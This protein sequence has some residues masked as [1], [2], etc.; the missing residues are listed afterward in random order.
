MAAIRQSARVIAF[1]LLFVSSALL[2][3]GAS[4]FGSLFPAHLAANSQVT[5][6][7]SGAAPI[8][9][10]EKL[11]DML[12]THLN[13]SA[14][15]FATS[16]KLTA[17]DGAADNEF[18]LAVAVD[19]D[20]AVVGARFADVNNK[21]NQGAAY[22]FVYGGNSWAWQA[23]LTSNDGLAGDEFGGAVAV[24]GDWLIVGARNA[25]AKDGAAYFFKQVNGTWTPYG[26]HTPSIHNTGNELFGSSVALADDFA[27]VGAE[28]A[29][30]MDGGRPGAAYVFRRGANNW[31]F[32]QRVVA[33]EPIT[34]ARFGHSV[35]IDGS[36]AL[37]GAP[38]A[39]VGDNAEQGAAYVFAGFQNGAIWLQQARLI[40][41][42]GAMSDSFGISVALDGNT[43]LIG[44]Y[45]AD[46]NGKKDQ[47]AA[48]VFVR[49]QSSWSLQ[50]KLLANGGAGR[51]RFGVATVLYGNTALVGA[52]HEDEGNKDDQGAAYLFVRCGPTWSQQARLLA[53]D[54]QIGDWFGASV[55]LTDSIA[56]VGAS[57]TG[58]L[59]EQR[60]P[61]A[62]YLFTLEQVP[63]DLSL[64]VSANPGELVRPGQELVY[65]L[66]YGNTCSSAASGVVIRETVPAHTRFD[67]GAS[68]PSVWSCPDGSG[69]GVICRAEIGVVAAE[70][71]GTL[72]FAVTVENAPPNDA[73][74]IVNH[75]L[76][77]D[78]GAHGADLVPRNN[79]ASVYTPLV[80]TPLVVNKTAMPT[81]A[82]P[83]DLITYTITISATNGEA[84]IAL[85]DTL[86][87]GVTFE[88]MLSGP[89]A[90]QD[91]QIRFAG[92]IPATG[93]LR[94]AYQAKIK[95]EVTPG[96]IL[97]NETLVASKGQLYAAAAGVTVAN[98]NPV[99]T[100]VLIYVVG[101]N[102][103]AEHTRRL[104]QKAEA[105]ASNDPNMVMLLLLD[106]PQT[107]DAYYYRLQ[108]NED[109]TEYCPVLGNFDCND[110]Y[111]IDKT[112]WQWGEATG[113]YSSLQEFV[114]RAI[115]V[116][117][118]QGKIILSLVGHG[119][120]W[121]PDFLAGQPPTHD[122]KPND[123]PLGGLLWDETPGISLSTAEL[124]LALRESAAETGRKIDLLYLDACLMAMSEVAYEVRDSVDY[125]L[126]SENWSWTSFR[127][128]RHLAVD[129]TLDVAEIGRQWIINEADELRGDGHTR[130][131]YPFTYS[132]LD[133]RHMDLLLEKQNALAIALTT[134]L[135][136]GNNKSLIHEAFEHT[137][138]FDGNQ[139]DKIE[140]GEY[141]CDLFS[142]AKQLESRFQAVPEIVQAALGVQSVITGSLRVA[143]SHNNG[144][145][146]LKPMLRWEWG[147]LGGVSIYLPL[148]QAD[149]WKRA[150][151]N[152]AHLRSAAEGAWDDFLR[153]YWSKTAPAAPPACGSNCPVKGPRALVNHHLY[154][155]I[156]T[157]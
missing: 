92:S 105:G 79:Q 30:I 135:A 81:N 99:Q 5:T 16:Y 27:L 141:Y 51:D 74:Q 48:Y 50:T 151:Y 129:M 98:K 114:T 125:L 102:N 118:P 101:D 96:S 72:L 152:A 28:G 107:D 4:L 149:D 119:G 128:D 55:A 12:R 132:L 43:A 1:I 40:D 68:T 93:S 142:F 56:L 82:Q 13:A 157:R 47:G 31:F 58:R 83:G 130:T 138:C 121:S 8:S 9:E 88:R 32:V 75:A 115:Q 103:L 25:N 65:T 136:S 53:A 20:T 67:A 123:D 85:T 113:A 137:E 143:E 42:S 133:L 3:A 127:Y 45:L 29:D 71:G 11:S 37:V 86:P 155:P 61:G 14:R 148:G 34:G 100:L 153:V 146:P 35:A 18:G 94:I 87:S 77:A 112:M 49:N 2:L 69:A 108:K 126:A 145:L 23:T 97:F 24:E 10:E 22:V 7:S 17:P 66:S 36:T 91:G 90:F 44:S 73:L 57:H 106:G 144:S 120:G 154:L 139:D 84:T 110:R 156:I 62:A 19:G 122:E 104:F 116:Y 95:T 134:T 52:R 78:D 6:F 54:G 70:T 140:V 21:D 147:E 76:I 38:S 15:P 111:H 64:E 117:Q 59:P 150:H 131:N 26:K 63:P 80:S 109:Q 60:G 33:D 41:A 89:G 124:G 46:V 39:K